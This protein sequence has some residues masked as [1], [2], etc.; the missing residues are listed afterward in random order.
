MPREKS[1]FLVHG[2]VIEAGYSGDVGYQSRLDR[3]RHR[4]SLGYNGGKSESTVDVSW[5]P[6]AADTY[7]ISP[8][9]SDY[10]LVPVPAVTIPLPNRNMQG[11]GFEEVTHFDPIYGRCV[12]QSFIGKP[13][14]LEHDNLDPKRAQGVI[15]DATLL[16]V[17]EWDVWKIVTMAAFDTTKNEEM[18][19]GILTNA[20]NKYSM[21]A[22]VKFFICSICGHRYDGRVLCQDMRYPGKGGIIRGYLVYHLCNGV[23]FIELS[24]V[25]DPA[26]PT[27]E[28][29]EIL[30]GASP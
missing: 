10:V 21:G 3:S 2:S 15:L 28:A 17:P 30:W 14:C 9:I 13:T 23:N 1:P 8:R 25:S 22:L 16:F 26:D 7:K 12:Y 29:P 24:N 20:R 5:L 19:D 6:W 18:C 27:A 4:L 11:F